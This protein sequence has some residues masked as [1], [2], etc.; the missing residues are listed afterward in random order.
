[1]P[2][3]HQPLRLVS[4][5]FGSPLTKLILELDFLRRNVLGGTTHPRIFFQLKSLFH[6]LESIGST[7][8]EGNNTTVAE[9]I[10]TKISTKVSV[11]NEKSLNDEKYKEIR[12]VENAMS[13]IDDNINQIEINK[14]F[15]SDLHK[16][17]VEG[18]STNDEGDKT[19]GI[20]RKHQVAI[21]N[22][23]HTPPV[24][25]TIIDQYMEELFKFIADDC[26][27]QFDLLKAAIAHHRFLWIHPF[28]NGNGRTVRLLTYAMLIKQGFR[29]NIG[30]RILNPSAV[31][32]SNRNDYYDH[33]S[34]ADTGESQ[35]VLEWCEYV[36]RGLKSEIEKID[37][38]SD[39]NFLKSK[40][41]IPALDSSLER[42]F[43]TEDE[44]KILR[45]AIEKQEIQAN[46]VSSVF[47]V[48]K[49]P[50]II[51]RYIKKLLYKQMLVPIEDK[52]RKYILRFDNNFLI[53]GIM[54]ALDNNDFLPDKS[55]NG[56]LK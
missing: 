56:K 22:S 7:R 51:S 13:F 34:K 1:M 48:K 33:L 15:V 3:V 25:D 24:S 39:Y 18:L 43:I 35:G 16:M 31:F 21:N 19:P 6:M 55:M 37:K 38:L 44:Y 17:V 32:C 50:S 14:S 42:K 27:S 12:N 29:I 52:R 49:D 28:G 9:Y 47:S 46:D 30:Q 41:L 36:L 26:F 54:T 11:K 4:P 8:I 2:L 23:N 20:Y 40:I 5:D 53:R 45:I 10:E